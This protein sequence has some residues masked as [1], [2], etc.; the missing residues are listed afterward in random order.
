M[1][2]SVVSSQAWLELSQDE[3]GG[4]IVL[5]KPSRRA[6]QR[7][8]SSALPLFDLAMARLSKR[9]L[10]ADFLCDAETV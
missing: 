7:K 1:R 3:N 6:P 10:D 9:R 2:F 5:Q 8:P 4:K